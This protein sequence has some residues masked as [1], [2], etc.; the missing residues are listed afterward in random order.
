[1]VVVHQ[2]T[3]VEHIRVVP[4][5]VQTVQHG[6]KAASQAG[7]NNIRVSPYLHIIPAQ[8]GEVLNE[9]QVD[10]TLPGILQHFQ[11]SGPLKIASAESIIHIGPGLYPAVEHHELGKK[12]LLIFNADRFIG[13]DV[14][15]VFCGT[16]S[17]IYTQTAVNSGS[18][19]LRLHT[20]VLLSEVSASSTL[21][22]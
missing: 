7:K 9:N 8:P 17:I 16:G 2:R 21:P 15:S 12:L 10:N 3:E 11:K 14:F 18:V 1:M 4:L 13:G 5:A 6:D 19:N 22:T 20:A